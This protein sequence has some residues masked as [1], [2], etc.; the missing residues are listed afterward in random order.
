MHDEVGVSAYLT[1][2]CILG[3]LDKFRTGLLW[4]KLADHCTTINDMS[5][6]FTSV[7]CQLNTWSTDSQDILDG[8]AK[9][10][11]DA[12]ITLDSVH[13]ELGTWCDN[14]ASTQALLQLLC[15]TFGAYSHRPL[16]DQLPGGKFHTILHHQARHVES[17]ATANELS[18][19][20]FA[21]L[22]RLKKKKP[23]VSILAMERMVLEK[24][25][26]WLQSQ[27][28]E[29]RKTLLDSTLYDAQEYKERFR[30]RVQEIKDFQQHQIQRKETGEGESVHTDETAAVPR[31]WEVWTFVKF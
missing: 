31:N 13:S 27:T 22:D 15:T 10:F 2:Y 8:R 23:I 21:Q 18:E 28:P 14:D 3:L 19:R 4:R 20:T 11:P 12:F 25:A 7:V 17:V 1:A 30:R 16:A 6:V 26:E 9:P 24:T 5:G 29:R